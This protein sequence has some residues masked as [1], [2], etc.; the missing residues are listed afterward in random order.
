VKATD[1]SLVDDRR[2]HAVEAAVVAGAAP[3]AAFKPW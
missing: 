2:K 3:A 1:V